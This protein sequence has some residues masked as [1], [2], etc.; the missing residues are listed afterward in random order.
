MVSSSNTGELPLINWVRRTI[1]KPRVIL[2]H[3][4]QPTPHEPIPRKRSVR[5]SSIDHHDS[6]S[7]PAARAEKVGPNFGFRND[8]HLGVNPLNRASNAPRD[9]DREIEGVIHDI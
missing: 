9:I 5:N 6:N 1:S 8:H 3:P 2:K 7:A 4:S